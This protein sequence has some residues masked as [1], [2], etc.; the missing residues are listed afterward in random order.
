MAAPKVILSEDSETRAPV[1]SVADRAGAAWATLWWV[2]ILLLLA[3]VVDIALA[4]Y[5]PNFK[6]P[7]WRFEVVGSVAGGLPL[8][9]VGLLAATMAA[10][11]G[12]KRGRAWL[13]LVLNTLATVSLLVML[14]T[15]V[16]V[17][18]STFAVAAAGAEVGLYKASF[19]TILFLVVFAG[20]TAT[21][22]VAAARWLR[23]ILGDV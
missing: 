11:A 15:F 6:E 20:A 14:I 16:T 19:K 21:S 17:M 23:S 1:L 2:G 9:I 7:T 18:S 3:G 8:P 22:V 5:P 4:F 12:R 10:L 13:A